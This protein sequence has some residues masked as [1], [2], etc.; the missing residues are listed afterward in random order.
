MSDA[1]LLAGLLPQQTYSRRKKW[2]TS[3]KS[4]M[5]SH[6]GVLASCDGGARVPIGDESVDWTRS[7]R[8]AKLGCEL[9]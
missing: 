2:V 4:M 5:R 8:A 6:C 3:N 1:C 7:L 9:G